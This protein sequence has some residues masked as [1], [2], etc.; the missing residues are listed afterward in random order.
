VHDDGARG[1]FQRVN[2]SPIPHTQFETTCPFAVQG[3]MDELIGV[4]GEP[5]QLLHDTPR[6]FPI[7]FSQFLTGF[8]HD[9]N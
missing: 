1:N 2:N 7:H 8:W 6:H 4:L 3:L 5:C 9:F